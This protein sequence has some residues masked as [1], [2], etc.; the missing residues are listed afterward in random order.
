MTEDTWQPPRVIE[1]ANGAVHLGLRRREFLKQAV[2]L[3][4]TTVTPALLPFAADSSEG[5]ST[6]IASSRIT[7]VVRRDET[8]MRYGGNGDVFPMTWTSDNRQF[9][10]FSDGFGWSNAPKVYYNTRAIR[11]DDG[12]VN[13]TFQEIAGYPEL[14]PWLEPR[15]Y[16]F[17]ALAVGD[18]IY[19]FLS[20][21]Q[22]PSSSG[23]WGW[24]G[25]KLIYSPDNGDTWCNQDGS[26]PVVWES[27]Q[28]RSRKSLLF[29]EEP[30]EA[31]ALVSLLQMEKSYEANRDGYVYGYGTN[32]GT[33]GVQNQL[34]MFRVSR[35][36]VLNRSAYEFFA[37]RKTDNSASWSRSINHR[38][39]VA[40]FPHGWVNSPHSGQTLVQ[41]WLP[42][43]VYNAPLD[44][45]MM[46]NSGIGCAGDGSR[47]GR[48]SYLGLWVAHHPW[49]PWTQIH[50]ETAWTPGNDTG[51]RCYSPQISPKWIAEDG[52]SF[53]LV[54]S[55]FKNGTEGIDL[56]WKDVKDKPT[57]S[58][59]AR[60]AKRWR[61]I[62]PY[63]SFNTQRFDLRTV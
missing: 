13:A 58:T 25:V 43:V 38:A 32:G 60:L 31:F 53:W 26:T 59:A 62:M 14:L 40:T 33:D 22:K 17:G 36:C 18:R 16:G 61:Q 41:S 55:D 23:W 12:P 34:V 42:S 24:N 4:I 57:A 2:A 49:G 51:A 30:Q 15:Y 27:Y 5:Q 63:Y 6:R 54:W 3:G 7:S 28:N 39:V 50:E 1:A 46:A 8:I 52:K 29:F 20:C 19:Q 56:V 9:S 48:P 11:I 44:L 47:F 37:G 21:S 35:D 45:Y 10:S